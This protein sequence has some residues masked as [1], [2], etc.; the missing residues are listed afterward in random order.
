VRVDEFKI[1]LWVRN[2]DV[3][4]RR[5]Q[6]GGNTGMT[7]KTSLI[8]NLYTNPQEDDSI[9]LRHLPASIGVVGEFDRYGEV[10]KRFPVNIQ[11]KM[12]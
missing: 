4:T 5:G 1:L 11:I 7:E 12:Y 8:F 10:L 3:H 9:G 2:P 6:Q